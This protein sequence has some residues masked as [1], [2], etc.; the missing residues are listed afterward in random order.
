M[1]SLFINLVCFDDS[2]YIK[3]RYFI[4]QKIFILVSK[5]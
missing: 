5:G 3:K 2:D 1:I 4:P